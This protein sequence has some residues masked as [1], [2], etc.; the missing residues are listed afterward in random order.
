MMQTNDM[1]FKFH[2]LH[3]EH[4]GGPAGSS[5][6]RSPTELG[7][8]GASTAIGLASDTDQKVCQEL[9]YD[10]KMLSGD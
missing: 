2:C 9:P 3:P 4:G 8:L 10:G 7:V 1:A 6:G 5:G